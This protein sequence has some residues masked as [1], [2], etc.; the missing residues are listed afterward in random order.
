MSSEKILQSGEKSKVQSGVMRQ[1]FQ[2]A[3]EKRSQ[4]KPGTSIGENVSEEIRQPQVPSELANLYEGG[5]PPEDV[6]N[7]YRRLPEKKRPSYLKL[8]A[9]R[10]DGMA[11]R[12]PACKG[13]RPRRRIKRESHQPPQV[14]DGKDEPVSTNSL[15]FYRDRRRVAQEE[16]ER[17]YPPLKPVPPDVLKRYRSLMGEQME[18]FVSGRVDQETI[19]S[20]IDSLIAEQKA[21]AMEDPPPREM[22]REAAVEDR[23]DVDDSRRTRIKKLRDDIAMFELEIAHPTYPRTH[24]DIE[25]DALAAEEELRSLESTV[26]VE[27]VHTHAGTS[28]SGAENLIERPTNPEGDIPTVEGNSRGQDFTIQPVSE[29][30]FITDPGSALDPGHAHEMADGTSKEWRDKLRGLIEVAENGTKEKFEWWKSSEEH[31][32]Q[33]S[34]ELNAETAKIRGLEGL[35]RSLGEKYN[36]YGWKTKL[37]VGLSLGLGAGALSTVSIPAAFACMSVVAIQRIAGMA[38]MFL[39]FEKLKQDEKWGKEIAMAKAIGY[40]VVMGS[41]M[42]FLSEG[43]KE[44]IDY[45]NQHQWG[46]SVHNWIGTMLGHH[47]TASEAGTVSE[48]AAAAPGAEHAEFIDKTYHVHDDNLSAT[49]EVHGTPGH[50]DVSD[51]ITSVPYHEPGQ[52]LLVANWMEVARQHF[53]G[54]GVDHV[55]QELAQDMEATR[56]A[57]EQAVANGDTQAAQTLHEN[58][59]RSLAMA[60]HD[61]GNI[62][63]AHVADMPQHDDVVWTEP[64]HPLPSLTPGSI[65]HVGMPTVDAA[66]GHGYEYMVKRLAEEL[67]DKDVKLPAGVNQNSDLAKLI[68]ADKGSLDDVVHRIAIDHGFFKADGA[69]V[70]IDPSA[71]MTIINGQVHLDDAMHSDIVHTTGDMDMHLTPPYHPEEV[72][73]HHLVEE[74]VPLS[75]PVEHVAA[76]NPQ[77]LP[78]AIEHAPVP[79]IDDSVV[80]DGTGGVVHD[81]EGN[82]V[83]AGTHHHTFDHVSTPVPGQEVFTNAHNIPINLTETHGYSSVKGI[84]YVMGG[85]KAI[86]DTQAQNYALSHHVPVFVDKSYKFLGTI[87][88]PRVVEYVPTSN[89]SLEMV[90]HHGP[91]LIPNSEDF[92][93]RIF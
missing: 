37:A 33:R 36:K 66:S 69:S 93:K 65:D 73:P 8:L 4:S 26:V 87:N 10:V 22:P 27:K 49:V 34:R 1:A 9:D 83:Y 43:V 81:A 64:S 2:R 92:T 61:F 78:I 90:I 77:P 54:I 70:R 82:P 25:R 55:V 50:S 68:S 57:L 41:A 17:I 60:Q 35:F 40:T 44:G 28:E 48:H 84:I 51:E 53:P 76:T 75:Q 62:F 13:N 32:T 46:E 88:V 79:T 23:I 14:N 16:F 24:D 91:S 21:K 56:L 47:T 20:R 58:L 12:K 86:I 74:T 67:H 5:T 3:R 19:A 89:G 11:S 71:H 30:M 38:T 31:L 18:N 52:Q 45:A 85:N 42:M 80:H 7:L 72:V 29:G 15:D 39:K 63:N 59:Q 6:I